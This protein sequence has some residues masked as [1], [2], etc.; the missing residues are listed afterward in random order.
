VALRPRGS[1]SN[2]YTLV[3]AGIR[4]VLPSGRSPEEDEEETEIQTGIFD[5][6][7][8]G[9]ASWERGEKGRISVP[10]TTQG[11]A[12]VDT[13]GERDVVEICA[14]RDGGPDDTVVGGIGATTGRP[15]AE[16]TPKAVQ[17]VH[18]HG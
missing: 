3:P 9:A 4:P 6:Q 1:E 16:E 17:A 14:V 12:T 18:V 7:I 13:G 11:A 10:D 5:A 8:G 15:V 2:K